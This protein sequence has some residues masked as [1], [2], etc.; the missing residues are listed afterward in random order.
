M[1]LYVVNKFPV[2][3]NF[4]VI[5]GLD[6]SGTSTQLKLFKK[7]LTKLGINN[8]CTF[9]PTDNTVGK[10]IRMILKGEN[11][12]EHETMALLFAA[13][14][15]EHLNSNKNGII[16]NIKEGKIVVCD[17]YIFSSLAYQSINCS[18]DWVLSINNQFPLPEHLIFIDTPPEVCQTRMKNRNTKEIYEDMDFQK[19]VYDS[20]LK[21]INIFN[22]TKMK[23]HN[24]DGMESPDIIFT[25]IWKNLKL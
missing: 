20:Y 9:E 21:S 1:E 3:K 2:L 14:R 10:F 5:E 11:A 16:K 12:V 23:V 7:R 24:I 4:I 19:K 13:D 22:K 17:R 25:Q 15:I 6:G 8:D 18:I